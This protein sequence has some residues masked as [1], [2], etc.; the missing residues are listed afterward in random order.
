MHPLTVYD[1]A[2]RDH[3]RDTAARLREHL[4]TLRLRDRRVAVLTRPERAE[5]RPTRT[6]P[7]VA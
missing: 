5:L 6:R 1:I 3:E 2:I 7:A 4:L